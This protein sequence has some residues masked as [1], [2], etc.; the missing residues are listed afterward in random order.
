MRNLYKVHVSDKE[1]PATADFW[2]V[3]AKD[4]DAAIAKARKATSDEYKIDGVEFI[5]GDVLA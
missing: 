4:V 2:W 3:M 5:R 1:S